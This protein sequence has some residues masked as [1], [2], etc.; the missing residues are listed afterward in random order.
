MNYKDTYNNRNGKLYLIVSK[1]NNIVISFM[2]DTTNSS[3]QDDSKL[4]QFR[5]LA[6]NY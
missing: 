4:T 5:K 2:S 3:S 1:N 6:T